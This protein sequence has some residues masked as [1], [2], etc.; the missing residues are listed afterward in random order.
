[1]SYS[2][3]INS[4]RDELR[5]L[6][7]L[8]PETTKSFGDLSKTVKD[9]GTISLKEKEFVALGIAV[10]QRCMPCISFHVK[11]LIKV[12]ATRDELGDVLSM[13][14]QMGGGPALMYSAHALACWDELTAE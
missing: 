10:A 12:G 4:I 9:S 1:M 6:N 11:A 8:I 3:D 5:A 13:A 2:D 7:K 14:I